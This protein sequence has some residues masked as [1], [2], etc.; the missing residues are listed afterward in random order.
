MTTKTQIAALNAEYEASK[1]IGL[2][3]ATLTATSDKSAEADMGE[4]A[5][6]TLFFTEEPELLADLGRWGFE[7]GTGDLTLI[8]A[9][10]EQ[11]DG[12]C[13]SREDAITRWSQSAVYEAEQFFDGRNQ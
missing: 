10:I 2:T 1:G 5:G 7:Y 4:D 13:I 12:F 3:Y 8:G 11:G 6:V 9:Y